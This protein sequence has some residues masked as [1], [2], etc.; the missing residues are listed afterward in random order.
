MWLS[1]FTSEPF[2]FAIFCITCVVYALTKKDASYHKPLT[3][4]LQDSGTWFKVMCL[5]D[6]KIK[7]KR[8]VL[9]DYDNETYAYKESWYDT[10]NIPTE[11]L[12]KGA[13]FTIT[14]VERKISFKKPSQ[15]DLIGVMTAMTFF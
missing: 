1:F 15:E 13:V 3:L 14:S 2:L 7:L 11:Y 4:T 9:I 6:K 12:V 10:T 8:S 5:K